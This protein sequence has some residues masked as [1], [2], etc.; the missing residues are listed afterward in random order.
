MKRALFVL[1]VGLATCTSLRADESPKPGAVN[2]SPREAEKAMTV[3]DGF[4]VTLFAGE[5]D[6]RQPNTFC[7][8]DRG[9]LWIGEN[10][11]YSKHGWNPDDRDRILIFED[12]DNDGRFDR[13]K[14]F[15][16]DFH[17]ISGIEI[18]FGGVLIGSPPNLLFLPDRNRDDVPDGEPVVVLDGWGRY[19]HHET[20]NSFE[21]GP[22]GWLYG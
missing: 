14:V 5:P 10:Y 20:L 2:L 3:P 8:D 18:G 13:R 17:Y 9:R 12:T 21:W 15:F 16:D 7:I 6:I 11:T 4:R 1:L 19:D 22:D